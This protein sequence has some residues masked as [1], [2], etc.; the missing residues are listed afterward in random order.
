ML[1]GFMTFHTSRVLW[2]NMELMSFFRVQR[3]FLYLMTFIALLWRDRSFP[4]SHLVTIGADGALFCHV[5][6]MVSSRYH[7][8]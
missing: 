2:L 8:T 6:I 1:Y 3:P 7:M 4:G 5:F